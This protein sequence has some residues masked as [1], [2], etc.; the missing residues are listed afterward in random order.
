MK[1]LLINNHGSPHDG[2]S[3]MSL[4]FRDDLRQR[5]HD[6]RLFASNASF[7]TRPNG[8]DYRCFG[9][10]SRMQML[11]QPANPSA[12]R[13]LQQALADFKPD[14][15][16][17]RTFLWQ[18][19]PF[20][21][22]L[23]REVPSL[24]HVVSYKA[25]CP[26]GT[27]ML[28]NGVG[29]EVSAGAA[30]YQS[31]CLPL[32]VWPLMMLQQKLFRRWRHVF[33]LVVATSEAVRQRLTREG[34]GVA[35][36]IS[37]AIPKRFMRAPLASPPTIAFAGRL[38][39]EKG[40]D[41][42]L[43][44][45][46][47]VAAQIPSARLLIAGDGPER[48]NLKRLTTKLRIVANVHFLGHLSQA[49]LER[50]FEVAWLQVVPSRWEEPFGLVAAEAMMRGTAVVATAVGALAEFIREGNTGFLVS[51]GDIDALAKRILCLMNNRELA[52]AMGRSGHQ[53]ALVRFDKN[54]YTEKFI[55]LYEQLCPTP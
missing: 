42:L 50:H 37:E 51:P 46:A 45:F 43:P 54:V 17:V 6:A 20:I 13:Q 48:E 36:V 10:H 52:E 35:A 16:H 32:R 38:T 41:L 24:Y 27:K 21:L 25:V 8:A 11:L 49:E 26:L 18:L 14:V 2:A 5:G 40:V 53:E 31:G 1:I 3:I 23:L 47:L 7:A 28:P 39:R 15:V 22:P 4:M 44:A 30:C 9:T 34:I 29:C 55:S 12:Y 19:S 33:N